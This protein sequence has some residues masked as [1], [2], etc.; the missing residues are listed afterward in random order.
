MWLIRSLSEEARI[1]YTR[2]AVVVLGFDGEDWL[3][4]LI[5]ATTE[6]IE[7][8]QEK[9]GMTMMNAVDDG[10][11]FQKGFDLYKPVVPAWIES[12]MIGDCGFK[13]RSISAR[14]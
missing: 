4:K 8:A 10:E 7:E 5:A 11:W 9:I 1:E 14:K 6:E 3:E 2:K 12:I 13:V